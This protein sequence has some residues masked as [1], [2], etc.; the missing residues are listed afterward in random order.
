MRIAI[1]QAYNGL[2][3]VFKKKLSALK[4]DS[5][6]FNIDKLNWYQVEYKKPDAYVWLADN[7]EERYHLI[8]DKVYFIEKI[9]NKHKL[10]AIVIEDTFLRFNVKTLKLLCYLAGVAVYLSKDKKVFLMTVKEVRKI[11]EVTDKKGVFDFVVDKYKLNLNFI[12]D[13]DITDAIAVALAYS[14]K[15]KQVAI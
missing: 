2:H 9:I 6:Y 3:K 11:L 12:K 10:D 4:V 8:H 1:A 5:F 14:I 13:N 15:L 7:K